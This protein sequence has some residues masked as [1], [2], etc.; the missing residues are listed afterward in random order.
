[1]GDE[2][3]LKGAIQSSLSNNKLEN[4][5]ASA[6]DTFD[7]WIA[8][9]DAWTN[10]N[11][12][13]G[14]E[15]IEYNVS[16]RVVRKADIRSW[17]PAGDLSFEESLLSMT[18]MV[19][20]KMKDDTGN[21]TEEPV[22]TKYPPILTLEDIL[23]G[24]EVR[25]YECTDGDPCLEPEE[26][27]KDLVGVYEQV[28]RFIKGDGADPGLQELYATNVGNLTDYPLLVN[29]L[30]NTTTP[31]GAM[32]HN[33]SGFENSSETVVNGLID[34]ISL[35]AVRQIGLDM[36]RDALNAAEVSTDSLAPIYAEKIK[37]NIEYYQKEYADRIKKL[38]A[39][40]AVFHSYK[41]ILESA[42][43]RQRGVIS[44]GPKG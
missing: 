40:Q 11:S 28:K 32:L 9:L 16:K 20:Q 10:A 33:L 18:G 26:Q 24:G 44:V 42:K 34:L 15:Q 25:Y 39:S 22:I 29:F 35:E 12:I 3:G 14:N 19:L 6:D 38:K 1:L 13:A 37:E 5:T 2:S 23:Y 7:N 30:G 21:V 4:M 41:M 43:P 31:V 27:T 8:D 17:Y 36:L